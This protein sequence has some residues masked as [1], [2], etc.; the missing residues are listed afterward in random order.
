MKAGPGGKHFRKRNH[1]GS[2]VSDTYD[3]VVAQKVAREGLC[4]PLDHL[5]SS[6]EHL[7][8]F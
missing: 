3:H 5:A 4:Q 7:S 1:R 2:M 8:K 6:A